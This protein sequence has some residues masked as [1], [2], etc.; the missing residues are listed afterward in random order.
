MLGYIFRRSNR[1]LSG[2]LAALT[3]VV[4]LSIAVCTMASA[5]QA[6]GWVSLD[7]PDN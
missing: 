1:A 7:G 5:L 3:G 6:G 2:R 4:V